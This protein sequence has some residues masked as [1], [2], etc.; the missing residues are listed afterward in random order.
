MAPDSGQRHQTLE[1]AFSNM[2][3]SAAMC[4][5]WVQDTPKGEE[6]MRTPLRVG[7]F[8]QEPEPGDRTLHD[9]EQVT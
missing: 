8:P 9:Q 3:N 1:L 2:A 6:D 7:L 4:W 5:P